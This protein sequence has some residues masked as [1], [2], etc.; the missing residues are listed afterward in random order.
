MRFPVCGQFIGETFNLKTHDFLSTCLTGVLKYAIVVVLS[1][2]I[3]SLR[4]AFLFFIITLLCTNPCV[5]LQSDATL[6]TVF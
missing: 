2:T 4:A 5:L 3:V 6:S 1:L